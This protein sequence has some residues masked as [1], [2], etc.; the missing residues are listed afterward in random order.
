M[1]A[2]TLVYEELVSKKR[3]SLH[4]SAMNDRTLAKVLSYLDPQVHTFTPCPITHDV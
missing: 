4:Y 1:A 3:D 2:T